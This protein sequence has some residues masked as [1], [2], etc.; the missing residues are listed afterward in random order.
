MSR[1]TV[2]LK[3]IDMELLSQRKN[4]LI[5]IIGFLEESSENYPD[6]HTETW[7]ASLHGLLNMIYDI[8]DV[9]W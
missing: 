3:N 2:V 5:D 9:G 8:E 4:D 6:F 7:I 1:K